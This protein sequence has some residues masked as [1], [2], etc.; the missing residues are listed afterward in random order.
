MYARSTTISNI[1]AVAI[2]AFMAFV[3]AF[4]LFAQDMTAIFDVGPMTDLPEMANLVND[5][6]THQVVAPLPD[7][8]PPATPPLDGMMALYFLVAL[9]ESAR[10]MMSDASP[11]AHGYS[12]PLYWLLSN[13]K[14]APPARA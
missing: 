6:G 5:S 7:P 13:P 2:C 14:T 11:T 1:K 12:A 10:R 3:L 4:V 8:E 9:A